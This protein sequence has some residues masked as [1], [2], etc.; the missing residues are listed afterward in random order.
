MNSFPTDTPE[1]D[2]LERLKAMRLIGAGGLMDEIASDLITEIGYVYRWWNEKE[3][4]QAEDD[5]T[6]L[7]LERAHRE[8]EGSIGDLTGAFIKVSKRLIDDFELMTKQ[9][10]AALHAI[11]DGNTAD[12][13]DRSVL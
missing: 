12:A 9:M 2:A 7:A 4:R 6:E 10:V 8:F 5:A 1:H 13:F 11:R 3:Q